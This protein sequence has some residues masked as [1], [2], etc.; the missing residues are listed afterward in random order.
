MDKK[1]RSGDVPLVD[2]LN[3][4]RSGT[5]QLPDFQRG[6]VWDDDHISSLPA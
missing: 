4:A 1:F 6:W 5:L 2:L 3:Q